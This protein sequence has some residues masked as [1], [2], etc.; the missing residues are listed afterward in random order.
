MS[1]KYNNNCTLRAYINDVL[2]YLFYLNLLLMGLSATQIVET[3]VINIRGFP[4]SS[5]LQKRMESN[6]F[7]SS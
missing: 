4:A 5:S 1:D 7:L 6:N 3:P 2:I